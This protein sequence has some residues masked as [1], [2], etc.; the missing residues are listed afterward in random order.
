MLSAKETEMI[1]EMIK[2]NQRQ[3]ELNRRSIRQLQ[4]GRGKIYNGRIDVTAETISQFKGYNQNFLEAN[5][6]LRG[7]ERNA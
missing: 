6:I 5:R 4:S 3:M 7:H 2:A 1:Q